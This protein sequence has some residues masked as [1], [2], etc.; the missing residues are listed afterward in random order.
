MYGIFT[1]IYHENQ[2]NVAKYTSP[3]D[4]MGNIYSK[5]DIARHFLG[6]LRSAAA[7]H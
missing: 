2:L 5:L 6:V 3:M 1:Y 4:P 7:V